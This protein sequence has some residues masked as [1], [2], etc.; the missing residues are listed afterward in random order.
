LTGGSAATTN[1][2]DTI[3][4]GA[5]DDTIDGG[6]GADTIDGGTGTNTL[7]TAGMI[8]TAIEGLNTGTSTGAVVNLGT[9]AVTAAT[10]NTAIGGTIGLS[11]SLATVAAG[12]TA[13]VYATQ[14]ALFSTVSD[15]ITNIQNV[16]GTGGADYIVGSTVTNVIT[17]GAG[18]DQIILGSA[19][20]GASDTVKISAAA[21]TG[22]DRDYISGFT[23]GAVTTSGQADVFNLNSG[24]ATLTG[25]NNFASAAAIQ[26]AGAAGNVAVAAATEVLYISAATIA[27][28]T[29]ANSLIGTNLL[30]AA[31]GT[32]TGAI[33]GQNNILVMVGIA[34][35]G[36]AVYYANSADNAIIA[37]E[38][39]LVGVLAGVTVGDL[40]FSNFSNVA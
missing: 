3:S 7:L 2:A 38:I 36:T 31:G 15:T 18:I 14:D 1:T 40:V 30:T 27:D 20:A 5:G 16:T 8:G 11:A 17:G 9:T 39:G 34:G 24:I 10:I 35:G 33:A 23:A 21:L 28:A 32:F 26:N 37:A 25:T 29:S 19:T 6:T 22:A 13:L 4:G 12:K